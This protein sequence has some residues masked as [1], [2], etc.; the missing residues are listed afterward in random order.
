MLT[1]FPSVQRSPR[2]LHLPF[3]PLFCIECLLV[4]LDLNLKGSLGPYQVLILV[5]LW[6]GITVDSNYSSGKYP[7]YHIL[8]YITRREFNTSGGKCYNISL[9]I[10]SGPGAEFL[11]AWIARNNS[12]FEKGLLQFSLLVW[13]TCIIFC[14]SLCFN[15]KNVESE[16]CGRDSSASVS[17]ILLAMLWL[18][19]YCCAPL[20]SRMFTSFGSL[21]FN[22]LTLFQA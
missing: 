14:S 9:W 22:C 5:Q 17:P 16:F 1:V 6:T 13:F 12:S 10:F 7:C 4:Q 3:S 8:L 11:V 19:F 21:P 18:S 2:V 20:T 15:S